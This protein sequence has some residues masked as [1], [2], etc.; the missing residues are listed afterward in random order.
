MGDEDGMVFHIG[1]WVTNKD[2]N[3][4]YNEC[5][6]DVE[7]WIADASDKSDIVRTLLHRIATVAQKNLI[8]VEYSVREIQ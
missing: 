8:S 7:R 6:D 4:A 3:Q 2:M 1:V 5:A